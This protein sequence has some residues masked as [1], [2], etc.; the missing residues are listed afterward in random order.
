[1]VAAVGRGVRWPVVATGELVTGAPIGGRA[2]R[3]IRTARSTASLRRA[4][5]NYHGVLL[6]E[7]IGSYLATEI[8]HGGRPCES[9]IAENAEVLG[10]HPEDFKPEQAGWSTEAEGKD[11][12]LWGTVGGNQARFADHGRRGGFGAGDAEAG[13]FKIR[14]GL[15]RA[16]PADRANVE[17]V[18]LGEN[19]GYAGFDRGSKAGQNGQCSRDERSKSDCGK[20]LDHDGPLSW[21]VSARRFVGWMCTHRKF[22]GVFAGSENGFIRTEFCFVARRGRNIAGSPR[23]TRRP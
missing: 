3:V 22:P 2:R 23:Q 11:A 19:L 10:G 17:P 14:P 8:D 7:M 21:A 1:M 18:T 4:A 12:S 16:I 9:R 5:A 13:S 6:P 20:C 15:L